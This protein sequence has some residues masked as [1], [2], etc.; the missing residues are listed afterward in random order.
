MKN[1]KYFLLCF[2]II[3]SQNSVHAMDSSKSNLNANKVLKT[4]AATLTIAGLYLHSQQ[5]PMQ[6][7]LEDSLRVFADAK[8]QATIQKPTITNNQ[9]YYYLRGSAASFDCDDDGCTHKKSALYDCD[10]EGCT[11]KKLAQLNC[12]DDGCNC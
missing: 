11:H 4:V 8:F 1:L 2:M 9:G 10:D 5:N 6:S 12:P 3:G 7:P